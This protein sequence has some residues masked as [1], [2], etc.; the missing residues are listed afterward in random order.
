MS[1]TLTIIKKLFLNAISGI[2]GLV[3]LI[4][5]GITSVALI[6]IEGTSWWSVITLSLSLS[7][8]FFNVKRVRL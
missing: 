2:C 8:L 7:I 5:L 1:F 3:V 4:S 6:I